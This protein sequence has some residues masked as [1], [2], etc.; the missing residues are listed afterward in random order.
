MGRR[1]PRWTLRI[2]PGTFLGSLRQDLVSGEMEGALSSKFGVRD[3]SS[4]VAFGTWRG[5]CYRFTSTGNG[6][7]GG[8]RNR[9]HISQQASWFNRKA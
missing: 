3:N 2:L 4:S 6:P 1:T 7:S 8:R 5:K 9:S